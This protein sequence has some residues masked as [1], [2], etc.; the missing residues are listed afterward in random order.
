MLNSQ[1]L[2]NFI[3]HSQNMVK[4]R[5]SKTCEVVVSDCTCEDSVSNLAV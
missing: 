1:A 5:F 4:I 3:D 2:F